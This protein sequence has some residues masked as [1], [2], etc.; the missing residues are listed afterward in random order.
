MSEDIRTH[1]TFVTRLFNTTE[2]KDYFINDYCF[3]DD[4]AQ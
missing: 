4:C 1:I 3:G 2:V